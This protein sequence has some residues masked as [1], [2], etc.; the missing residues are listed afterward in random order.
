MYN[1]R[2]RVVASAGTAV[3]FENE[4]DAF[5]GV[6]QDEVRRHGERSWHDP[7]MRVSMLNHMLIPIQCQIFSH[8]GYT[9]H[10]KTCHVTLRY[11]SKRDMLWS[12]ATKGQR[13]GNQGLGSFER[14][15][16]GLELRLRARMALKSMVT[17]MTARISM[18]QVMTRVHAPVVENS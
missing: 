2:S 3:C 18:M 9:S 6:M 16:K 13:V 4:A 8:F 10:I 17:E 5:R 14:R 7:M 12:S 11:R 15:F 1:C